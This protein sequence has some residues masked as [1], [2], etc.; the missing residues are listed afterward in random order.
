M[1]GKRRSHGEGSVFRRQDGR[2]R[3]VLDLGWIDG[4]RTRRWVYGTTERD[5]LAK[6]A[7]LKDAQRK[8]QNLTASSRTFGE[9]L[10][11]WLAMKERQGTRAST[12]RGY[13]WLIRL[14]IRPSLGSKR[15]DKLTPTDVRQFVDAKSAT[16][17]SGQTVRLIHSLVRNVLADAEREELV[18]RNVARLVRPPSVHREEVRVLTVEDAKRLVA[19]IRG[20]HLEALWLCALTLGLRRG[21]LLGLKWGDIDFRDG[22]LTVRRALQRASTGG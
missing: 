4:K 21:E 18:H 1:S 17:L 7:E 20:D 8:G 14:H 11:E 9:W 3:G 12:M 2:W 6:L 16:A 13:R 15:L 10:D 19:A 5:V 22:L